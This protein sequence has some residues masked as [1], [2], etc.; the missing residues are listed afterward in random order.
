MPAAVITVDVARRSMNPMT[1]RTDIGPARSSSNGILGAEPV[2]PG[3]RTIVWVSHGTIE[4][5][6]AEKLGVASFHAVELQRA[7]EQ[8]DIAVAMGTTRPA[9]ANRIVKSGQPSNNGKQD[10]PDQI[11]DEDIPTR[12]THDNLEE[13]AGR[14]AVPVDGSVIAP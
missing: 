5:G 6:P 7:G 12:R 3:P 2:L 1:T 14:V 10:Q 13:R 9:P 4:R 8:D 11:P